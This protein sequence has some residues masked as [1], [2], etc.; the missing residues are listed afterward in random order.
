MAQ[1]IN[2]LVAAS[3]H[4]LSVIIVGV[5]GADFSQM[6]RLDGDNG[7]LV[8]TSG[9]RAARDIVQFV[10]FRR[11]KNDPASLAKQTLAEV[12][13]QVLSFARMH[14]ISPMPPRPKPLPPA[15][16]IAP[17]APPLPANGVQPPKYI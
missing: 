6:D 10:P 17:S 4:P 3:A 1:T 5:G 13:S 16:Q 8:N 2:A 11:F 9:Q 7:H 14:G 12:P 15:S